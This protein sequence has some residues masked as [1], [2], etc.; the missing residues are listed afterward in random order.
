MDLSTRYILLPAMNDYA[1]GQSAVNHLTGKVI[2][3][4]LIFHF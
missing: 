4:L 2:D 3:G 1:L